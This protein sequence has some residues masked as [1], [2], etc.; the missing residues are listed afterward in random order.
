M[1]YCLSY[2]PCKYISFV[3]SG[4]FQMLRDKTFKL[5]LVAF[6]T[7]KLERRLMEIKERLIFITA[8]D[9]PVDPDAESTE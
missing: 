1:S 4:Q 3:K 2:D 5:S 6:P 7:T 9:E 8:D